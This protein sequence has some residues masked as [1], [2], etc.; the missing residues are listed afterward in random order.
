MKNR[1]LLSRLTRASLVVILL[2][3]ALAG[4]TFAWLT[5]QTPPITNT[6][7][8]GAVDVEIEETFSDGKDEKSNVTLK[9][10]ENV[11]IYVRAAL[12]PTWVD[13]QGKPHGVAASLNDDLDIEWGTGDWIYDAP[14]GYYYYK[15]ILSAGESTKILIDSATVR[16][17]NDYHMNLQVI[18]DAVQ[19]SPASAVAEVWPVT[20]DASGTLQ[21]KGGGG[22]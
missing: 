6:F 21:V 22:S 20:V 10:Q 11:P 18:A 4:G 13:D 14:D 16:T 3:L 19:A 15:H 5:V 17:A 8:M 1:K 12:V 2:V 7:Q 9:N